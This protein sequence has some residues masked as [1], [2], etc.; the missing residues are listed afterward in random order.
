MRNGEEDAVPDRRKPSLQRCLLYIIV[1]AIARLE[2]PLML[3]VTV[4]EVHCDAAGLLVLYCELLLKDVEVSTL[5][6][7]EIRR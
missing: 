4:G 2:E 5:A 6:S 3:T 1:C 7:N